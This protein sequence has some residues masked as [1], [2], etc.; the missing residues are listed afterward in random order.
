MPVK[1]LGTGSMKITFGAAIGYSS[2]KLHPYL[3]TEHIVI[4]LWHTKNGT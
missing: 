1:N 2:G 3:S 4:I